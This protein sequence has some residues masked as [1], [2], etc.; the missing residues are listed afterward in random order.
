M[1]WSPKT[2]P[3]SLP[4]K[5][6]DHR[7]RPRL[8]MRPAVTPAVRGRITIG[9]CRRAWT[10]EFRARGI[11]SPELDAR[12]LIGHALGLD[13]AALA[14]RADQPLSVEQQNAVAALARRRLAH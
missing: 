12:D 6:R 11:A 9:D 13:H 10:A 1:R 5:T 8:P 3:P 14:A 7:L 2:R 4:R